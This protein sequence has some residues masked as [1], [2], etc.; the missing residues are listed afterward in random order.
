VHS[1]FPAL[2][3]SDKNPL[4]RPCNENLFLCPSARLRRNG[5]STCCICPENWS[6]Q[7]PTSSC[8]QRCH[9]QFPS[10][11]PQLDVYLQG[12]N[13]FFE[14]R[15]SHTQER[16]H[17]KHR[18]RGPHRSQRCPRHK[19]RQNALQNIKQQTSA[20]HK[21]KENYLRLEPG[22]EP[23]TSRNLNLGNDPKRESYH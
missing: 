5:Q 2:N 12:A 18:Q 4:P 1:Q 13:W 15:R 7:C 16:R 14:T 20:A 3:A 9:S 8:C 17:C 6:Y 21:Q 10:G 11:F 23:G 19:N 22:F